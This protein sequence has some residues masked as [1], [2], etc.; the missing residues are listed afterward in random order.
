M[1][2]KVFIIS[3][4]SGALQTL[5]FQPSGLG[6]FDSTS[7]TNYILI[8]RPRCGLKV[9]ALHMDFN[10]RAIVLPRKH[11]RLFWLDAEV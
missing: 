3:L 1:G 10:Y 8:K 2:R 5:L 6:A 4:W 9:A 11:K 7:L